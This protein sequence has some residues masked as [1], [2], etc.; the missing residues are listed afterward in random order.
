MSQRAK[1]QLGE[2]GAEVLTGAKVT[3]I[4]AFGIHYDTMG[5]A[6]RHA[7]TG[8]PFPAQPYC[9]VGRWRAASPLGR[10]LSKSTRCQ[11]DRAGRVVVQPDLTIPDHSNIYV[12]GDLASA[13]AISTQTTPPWFPVSP[14]AKQMGRKA[15][16]NIMRR[17]QG[18]PAQAFRYF[19]YGNL[20]TIGKRAAVAVLDLAF[21]QQA[22]EVQRLLRPGCS[23]CLCTF[24][25]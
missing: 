22:G 10:A 17:L 11:L 5:P 18:K 8:V 7:T 23:G 2:L 3:N 15:A 12:V 21:H 9:G 24:T 19:D 13:R 20:A 1:E 14:G 16:F 6:R 4:T 25:S